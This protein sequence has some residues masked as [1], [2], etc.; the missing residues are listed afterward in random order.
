MLASHGMR[1]FA[2]LA[3]VALSACGEESPYEVPSD[4]TAYTAPAVRTATAG[5]LGVLT[6]AAPAPSPRPVGAR[7]RS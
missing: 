1:I 5:D 6:G 3:A 4:S 2:L 7:A